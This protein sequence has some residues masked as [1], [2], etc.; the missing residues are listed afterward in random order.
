MSQM[1]HIL[2]FV[3]Y[4]FIHL[5]KFLWFVMQTFTT[6]LWNKNATVSTIL[7]VRNSQF[8]MWLIY[9]EFLYIFVQIH[10]HYK[11]K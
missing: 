7:L 8:N 6:L 4:S 2:I 5:F 1:F 9:T 11:G 10:S 3:F